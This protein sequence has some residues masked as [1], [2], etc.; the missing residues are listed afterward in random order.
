MDRQ[1]RFLKPYSLFSPGDTAEMLNGPAIELVKRG[2]CEYVDEEPE[3]MAIEPER[4]AMKPAPKKR[5]RP[6]KVRTS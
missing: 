6:R 2:I 4:N 1:V 3:A 5:G